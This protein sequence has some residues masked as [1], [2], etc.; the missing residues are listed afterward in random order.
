[1]PLDEI[2]ITWRNSGQSGVS[3]IR[4]GEIC[5]RGRPGG[6][7]VVDGQRTETHCN[8]MHY[9]VIIVKPTV[10]KIIFNYNIV[11]RINMSMDTYVYWMCRS[12]KKQCSKDYTEESSK[13]PSVI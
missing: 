13:N 6:L 1:M 2:D 9:I 4:S 5:K 8:F 11:I 3:D 12:F 10:F 7:A